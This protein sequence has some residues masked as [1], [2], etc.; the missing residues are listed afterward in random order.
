MNNMR[1]LSR[2]KPFMKLVLTAFIVVA[3]FVSAYAL[4]YTSTAKSIREAALTDALMY[5]T[6]GAREIGGA[7]YQNYTQLNSVFTLDAFEPL[8]SE[9]NDIARPEQYAQIIMFKRAMSTLFSSTN[10]FPLTMIYFDA[11]T[12]FLCSSAYATADLRGDYDNGLIAYGDYTFDEF[13][14]L[15]LAHANTSVSRKYVPAANFSLKTQDAPISGDMAL[16]VKR[17]GST[18]AYALMAIDTRAMQ[19]TLRGDGA[20]DPGYLV[21]T[22]AVGDVYSRGATAERPITGTTVYDKDINATIMRVALAN[23]G[24][25]A[26]LKLLDD[27]VYAQ[28]SRFTAMWY[29]LLALFIAMCVLLLVYAGVYLVY[30]IE[31]LIHSARAGGSNVS[32]LKH[33]ESELTRMRDYNVR[34]ESNVDTLRPVIRENLMRKLLFGEYLSRAERET[35]D[36]FSGIDAMCTY[37]VAVAGGVNDT[38]HAARENNLKLKRIIAG[39]FPDGIVCL[40]SINTF[41]VLAADADDVEAR[42]ERLLA[43]INALAGE[44]AF[45]IGVSRS[46]LKLAEAD[47][48]FSE[49]NAAFT[50]AYALQSSTVAIYKEADF[51]RL[52]Y[53]LNY[54]A[55]DKLYNLLLA[56]DARAACEQFEALARAIFPADS[57]NRKSRT[58]RKQFFFDAMGVLTRLSSQLGIRPIL[59]SLAVYDE[60]MRFD[61]M[62]SLISHAFEY[63]AELSQKSDGMSVE[64]IKNAVRVYVSERYADPDMSLALLSKRFGMSESNLSKFFKSYQGVNFSEY[65][66]WLR[67]SAAEELLLGADMTMSQ[68]AARVGYSSPT[69][70]YRA[71]KRRYGVSPTDWAQS[72]KTAL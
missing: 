63:I 54:S 70:F 52:N 16:F 18:N 48:L 49:A 19:N 7:F 33:V 64:S 26:Y 46:A 8:S 69:S 3:V 61:D 72:V 27:V 35:L 30:P 39:A 45:A 50:D 57:Y 59:D 29:I 17:L 47:K 34:L 20:A 44:N 1:A 13:R 66:E 15:I 32:T 9:S 25:N 10:C 28:I 2:L 14:A 5:L 12:P 21:L 4:I 37:R 51:A 24:M 6:R 42:L 40:I 43:S 41:A 71:F 65:L 55:L 22:S 67:L 58:V 23:M 68:V 62:I 56:G 36:A 53:A 11:R 38:R 31:R 60:T